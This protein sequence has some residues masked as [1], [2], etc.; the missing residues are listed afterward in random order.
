MYFEF[1]CYGTEVAGWVLGRETVAQV[2]SHNE[3]Q[4]LLS[5]DENVLQFPHINVCT[6]K[7]TVAV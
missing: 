4:T 2:I 1:G 7:R 6:G 5:I 3:K